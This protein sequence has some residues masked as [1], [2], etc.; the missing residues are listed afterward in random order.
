MELKSKSVF[1]RSMSFTSFQNFVIVFVTFS[2]PP[3]GL[4]TILYLFILYFLT[5]DLIYFS[6]TSNPLPQIMTSRQPSPHGSV[7]SAWC[8]VCSQIRARSRELV[9]V[10]FFPKT[11]RFLLLS[12][13]GNRSKYL[14]LTYNMQPHRFVDRFKA[15]LWGNKSKIP[16]SPHTYRRSQYCTL[17]VRF[18]LFDIRFL[19][20]MITFQS[21]MFTFWYFWF[22]LFGLSGIVIL[23]FPISS[24][25]LI[26]FS[27]KF[28]LPASPINSCISFRL[29]GTE[30]NWII[31]C[32]LTCSLSCSFEA[33]STDDPTIAVVASDREINSHKFLL[34]YFTCCI[35]H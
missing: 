4:K 2:V 18:S 25:G 8:R 11:H 32:I 34:F 22:L 23:I 13:L 30:Q 16:S 14:A 17:H 7:A 24:K 33:S 20:P 35:S 15:L 3:V 19:S 5:S 28:L 6:F 9:K 1:E 21:S 12:V 31:S 29:R 27:E 10:H 26:Y